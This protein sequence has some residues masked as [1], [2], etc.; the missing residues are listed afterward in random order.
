VA[1]TPRRS[2]CAFIGKLTFHST[3]LGRG[4]DVAHG[5]RKKGVA[6]SFVESPDAA[7]LSWDVFFWLG[8][9]TS[10][11]EAGTAAYKTVELDDHLHGSPVQYREVQGHESDRFRSLFPKGVRTLEGGI[12]SGFHHVGPEKYEPRLL[13]IKGR[14]HIRIDEVPKT[15]KSL[16]SGDVFVLDAGHK[17]YQW[18]GSSAS[19]SEKTKASQLAEAIVEERLGHASHVVVDEGKDDDEFFK[20]LGDKGPIASAAA[21]GSD[22]E[23]D[24][25]AA[26]TIK[27]FRLHEEGGNLSFKQVAEGEKLKK[28]DVSSEDVYV[29]DTGAEVIAWVGAKSSTAEKKVAL[30]VAVDYVAKHGLPAHT[31]VSRVIEGGENEVWAHYVH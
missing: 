6:T 15:Y 9:T 4:E 26:Q 30:Q 8:A 7:A 29:L 13:H 2:G 18:L 12:E 17:I 24:K 31:P 16:N 25:S 11:D 21:G 1:S 14:K 27:L 22:L 10:Q 19:G 28:S 5:I 3:S 20:A 23:S